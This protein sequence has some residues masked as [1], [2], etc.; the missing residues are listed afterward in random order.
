MINNGLGNNE[1]IT[2]SKPKI[3]KFKFNE[4]INKT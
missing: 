2:E 4:D 3:F 1:M